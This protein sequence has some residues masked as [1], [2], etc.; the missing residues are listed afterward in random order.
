MAG[1]PAPTGSEPVR[2]NFQ[3]SDGARLSWL[4]TGERSSRPSFLLVPGWSMPAT[5]WQRQMQHLAAGRAVL[6][7]DPRGQGGSSL[8]DQGYDIETRA[9]DLHEFASAHAPLIIVG[10][11]LAALE[12]L[13]A[14]HRY[15]SL[16]FAGIVLVDSSVGEEPAPDAGT[17]FLDQLR[18]DRQAAVEQF[19]HAMFHSEQPET[20]QQDL[21]EHALRLPLEASISLFPRDIPREHWRNIARALDRPLLYVVSAQFQE[22]AFNLR[23]HRARTQIEVFHRAGHALFADEPDRFNRLLLHFARTLPATKPP[24][25]PISAAG[26]PWASGR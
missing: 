9:R 5:I 18:A 22:Q 24:G 3:T 11:S 23:L 13:Q 6:A 1:I 4:Q 14:V 21:V 12:T 19:V 20:A 26:A 7:L 17:P 2:L 16:P 25:R 8:P 10:W 15:G